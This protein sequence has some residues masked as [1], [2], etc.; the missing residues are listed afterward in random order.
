MIVTY[1]KIEKYLEK[2]K[3]IENKNE[4]FASIIKNVSK[5]G[6]I[7][8]L[9]LV[10]AVDGTNI[11][12]L[13]YNEELPIFQ[14]IPQTFFGSLP[15]TTREKTLKS[16]NDNYENFN[17]TIEEEYNKIIKILKDL[18]FLNIENAVLQ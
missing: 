10:Q 11:L 18:K 3:K 2:I 13:N 9:I 8:P 5:D 17:N 14:I 12:T 1:D 16:Y 4:V 7:S 6:T 15:E